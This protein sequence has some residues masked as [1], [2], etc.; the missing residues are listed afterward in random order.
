M[1]EQRYGIA[2]DEKLELGNEQ[3]DTQHQRLFELLNELVGQCMD[4]SNIEKLKGTLDFLVDYTVYHFYDEESL[5]VQYNFSDYARHKQLHEDF[6]ETVAALV[7]RLAES[8]SSEELSNDV[9]KIV[10]RWLI[11]HIQQE[12]KKIGEHIRRVTA[13]TTYA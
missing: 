6:K 10:V 7:R 12:D 2:W 4:G 5:Q 9:N 3:V 11:G 13:R 8:G 1:K